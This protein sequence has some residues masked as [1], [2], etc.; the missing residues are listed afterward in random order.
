M[1]ADIGGGHQQL[2]FYF[3]TWCLHSSFSYSSFHLSLQWKPSQS[4]WQRGGPDHVRSADQP[5]AWRSSVSSPSER[6]RSSRATSEHKHDR[7][8]WSCRPQEELCSALACVCICTVVC[9]PASA[10]VHV[11]VIPVSI[12]MCPSQHLSVWNTVRLS[13]LASECD[14]VSLCTC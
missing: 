8:N 7:S 1:T 10:S 2:L 4:S 5:L 11:C 14:H 13:V 6:Q 12:Y 9:V 3:W